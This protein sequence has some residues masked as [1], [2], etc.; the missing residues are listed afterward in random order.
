ME[1]CNFFALNKQL[2]EH[3]ILSFS[4]F[5]G[6]SATPSQLPT[7]TPSSV[8]GKS[9]GIHPWCL[10]SR[11]CGPFFFLLFVQISQFNSLVSF[12]SSL[13]FKNPLFLPIKKVGII[14]R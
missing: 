8:T 10:G 3:R 11:V 12:S 7:E 6:T 4:D 13:Y 5:S 14:S 1:K 9:W 2:T